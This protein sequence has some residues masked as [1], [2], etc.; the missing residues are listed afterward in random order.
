MIGVDIDQNKIKLAEHNA[1]V[2]NVQNKIKLQKELFP[3]KSHIQREYSV[4]VTSMSWIFEPASVQLGWNILR[5]RRW[6]KSDPNI[7][8][9]IAPK[10]AI[11]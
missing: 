9:E 4:H 5:S 3:E 1:D 10:V 7:A 8:L 6:Q 2:Y 11:H